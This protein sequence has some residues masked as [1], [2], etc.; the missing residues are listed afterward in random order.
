MTCSM[1][2]VRQSE[3]LIHTVAEACNHANPNVST[4]I[5]QYGL[6]WINIW[7]YKATSGSKTCFNK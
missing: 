6:S 4:R 5:L 2:K 7:V 3:N 1:R